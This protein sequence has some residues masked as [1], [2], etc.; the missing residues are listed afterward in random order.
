MSHCYKESI[1]AF[2][3]SIIHR[4]WHQNFPLKNMI[5]VLKEMLG[6]FWIFVWIFMPIP[7]SNNISSGFTCVIFLTRTECLIGFTW[8]ICIFLFQRQKP[9]FLCFP[10]SCKVILNFG[11]SL[12]FL[13]QLFRYFL[14]FVTEWDIN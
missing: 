13:K 14:V 7:P 3:F 2:S 1:Q 6:W 5:M 12:Q 10:N 11:G 8:K 9:D 4:C